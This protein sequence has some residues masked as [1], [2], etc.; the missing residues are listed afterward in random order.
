[1]PIAVTPEKMEI[2]PNCGKIIIETALYLEASKKDGH[3]QKGREIQYLN[4]DKDN[5]W[6]ERKEDGSKD[7]Y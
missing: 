3:A 6:S 4:R 5:K 1:M 7:L 2:E